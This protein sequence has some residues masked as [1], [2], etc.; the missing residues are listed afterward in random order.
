M[1]DGDV[2]LDGVVFSYDKTSLHEELGETAH[3]LDTRF[4]LSGKVRRPYLK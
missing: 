4:L 3:H 1:D 2:G